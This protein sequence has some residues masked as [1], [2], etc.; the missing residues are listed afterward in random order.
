MDIELPASDP[1]YKARINRYVLSGDLLAGRITRYI[2]LDGT[3]APPSVSYYH[4]DHLNS[5]KCVTDTT[6]K[7]EV[8]YVYRAFGAQLAKLGSGDAKYSFSGKELDSETNLYYFNA[9][10]YDAEVGRFITEDPA[11]DGLNWYGYCEE[12]PLKFK[13]PT[14]LKVISTKT[15]PIKVKYLDPDTH[16]EITGVGATVTTNWTMTNV[17]N[18]DGSQSNILQRTT[19]TVISNNAAGEA[20]VAGLRSADNGVKGLTGFASG[21]VLDLVLP[22]VGVP[23]HIARIIGYGYGIASAAQGFTDGSIT[24]E[25]GGIIQD[26]T[27]ISTTKGIDGNI[28]SELK[29]TYHVWGGPMEGKTKDTTTRV[30]KGEFTYE[31]QKN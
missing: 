22:E 1:T 21:V 25:R 24:Y 9:R 7:L 4:L 29:S 19:T 6:G 5:T 30:D 13:D 11:K 10:F 3:E 15:D 14:G 28:S 20:F 12:N 2:K 26:K 18:K 27:T 17:K 23:A 8:D 16:K 31:W